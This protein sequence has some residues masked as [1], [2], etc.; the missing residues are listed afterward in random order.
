MRTSFYQLR[1]N[2]CAIALKP[3]LSPDMAFFMSPKTTKTT[4]YMLASVKLQDAFTDF[5]LSRHCLLVNPG[6]LRFCR[7]TAARFVSWLETQSIT[8]L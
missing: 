5:W 6:T 4:K 1:S 3:P 8:D 2:L 7:F